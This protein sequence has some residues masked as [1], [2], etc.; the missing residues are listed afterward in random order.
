MGRYSEE[1]LEK[2]RK[3]NEEKFVSDARAKF[4]EKFDYSMIHYVRQKVPIEI[5]C[6]EHGIFTQTPEKH[7]QSRFGCPKCGVTVRAKKKNYNGRQ[8]FED[9]FAENFAETL[10][11]LTPYRRAREVVTLRCKRHGTI[12]DSVPYVL[13]NA[14]H[15]CP[16]CAHEAIGLSSRIDHDEFL[17]RCIEKFGN[18]FDLSK[19]EYKTANEPMTIICPLH[20][21]FNAKPVNFLNS[22]HGCPKCGRLHSGYAAERIR[23]IEAGE[24]KPRV[25]RLAL[26]RVEVFGI[27]AYKLGI[28]SRRLIDRY[29]FALREVIFETTL[30]ELNALKLEQQLHGKYFKARDVRIFLAGLRAGKRWPGDSEIYNEEFIPAI[31]ADL[32]VAVDQIA[33]DPNYWKGQPKLEAPILRI[34][35]VRKVGGVWN[36]PKS[37]IRLDTKE[38]FNSVTEAAKAVGSTQ[39]LVSAV[40]RGERGHTKGVQFVWQSDYEAGNLPEF[41]PKNKGANHKW[42]RAVRCI[43]TGKVYSTTIEAAADTGAQASKITSVCRGKRK[44]AAGFRWEYA[45][46]V[47][48]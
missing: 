45:N 38:V 16:D 14:V 29:A 19:A 20:G 24:V 9:F 15:G 5:R 36:P 43:E 6:P 25:T 8:K 28:T 7:L 31:L 2:G 41:T 44:K 1:A 37:V 23:K 46:S 4:G 26:M 21:E 27:S 3:A 35:T 47:A 48:Y 42:A 40:C 11:I 10:E 22:S 33:T 18:Q 39:P 12:F 32:K 13:F 17:K 30:D 34:R